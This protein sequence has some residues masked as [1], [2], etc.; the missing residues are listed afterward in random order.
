MWPCRNE[1][2][3][4][5]HENRSK[6][7]FLKIYII[8]K[9]GTDE[10]YSRRELFFAFLL[11]KYLILYSTMNHRACRIHWKWNFSVQMDGIQDLFHDDTEKWL[12]KHFRFEYRTSNIHRNCRVIL[13]NWF[14]CANNW[15]FQ[16][17]HSNVWYKWFAYECCRSVS[18]IKWGK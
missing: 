6:V 1:T 8:P 11:E 2:E 12:H 15:N 4:D 16:R 13:S 14:V 7:F 10:K 17:I 9:T 18:E 5:F 3:S